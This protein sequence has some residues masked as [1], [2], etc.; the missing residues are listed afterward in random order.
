MM[1]VL[2]RS[3]DR[4]Y[5]AMASWW[6]RSFAVRTSNE[7]CCCFPVGQYCA[8]THETSECCFESDLITQ[9]DKD[10]TLI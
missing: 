5:T 9:S 6:F 4:T 10:I 8:L 1:K 2:K 3:A 7:F